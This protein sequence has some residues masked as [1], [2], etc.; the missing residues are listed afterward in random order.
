MC[1]CKFTGAFYGG[2]HST[3]TGQDSKKSKKEME[4]DIT[5]SMFSIRVAEMKAAWLKNRLN[6]FF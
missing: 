2:G 1:Y 5:Q 6:S 4:R 3:T